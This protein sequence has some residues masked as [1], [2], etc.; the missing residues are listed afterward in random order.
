MIRIVLIG[1]EGE[2]NLGMIARIAGNFC[3]N[4][5]YLVSPQADIGNEAVRYSV[6]AADILKRSVIVD[7]LERALDGVDVSFC[8]TAIKRGG[9]F[10]RKTIE[11]NSVI[12][13]V[14]KLIPSK[15]AF[16]FGRESTGLT[17]GELARCDY[18]F[19]IE[20]CPSY[21][22]L[23]LANSVAITMYEIYRN[24]TRKPLHE[25]LSGNKFIEQRNRLITVFE[26][27]SSQVFRDEYRVKN[28]KLLAMKLAD[29][30]F[31]DDVEI[32]LLL[33]LMSRLKGRL[34]RCS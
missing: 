19:T 7:S 2:I 25:G 6:R 12:Q 23:N 13:I 9:D 21:P 17:R 28:S 20:T 29:P 30:R 3:I 11:L 27:L 24:I 18:R 8:S 1:T 33:T 14:E 16:V 34:E 15:V 22:T 26:H 31:L 32:G 5:L 10:L 4:E